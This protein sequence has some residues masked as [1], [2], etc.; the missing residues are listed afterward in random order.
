MLPSQ[1]I[2]DPVYYAF[3]YASAAEKAI[4]D[5]D[6]NDANAVIQETKEIYVA[7]PPG[8]TRTP[9]LMALET[10][11]KNA[12]SNV[13]G[14]KDAI[15]GAQGLIEA[16]LVSGDER[17]LVAAISVIVEKQERAIAA[18]GAFQATATAMIT[19]YAK[20]EERLISTYFNSLLTV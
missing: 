3:K 16:Q 8:D 14:W 20:A 2:T 10:A 6:K 9:Q 15:D 17:N 11:L 13:N 7:L 12:L 1:V 18:I 5:T 19:D 4:D